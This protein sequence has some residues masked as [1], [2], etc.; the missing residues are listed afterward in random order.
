MGGW[1]SYGDAKRRLVFENDTF[2]YCNKGGTNVS[3]VHLKLKKKKKSLDVKL[4]N[5]SL[6]SV[7]RVC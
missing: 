7:L 4:M 1:V 3:R 5:T 2:Y 6:D